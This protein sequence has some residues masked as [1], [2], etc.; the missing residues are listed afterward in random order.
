MTGYDPSWDP[1]TRARVQRAM[2]HLYASVTRI[3]Y[4]H[5][6]GANGLFGADSTSDVVGHGDITGIIAVGAKSVIE[7]IRR[8]LDR[9]SA[10]LAEVTAET[11]AYKRQIYGPGYR[12]SGR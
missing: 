3:L 2:D 4:A 7:P 12:P 6:D 11:D 9:A 10:V 1:A 8:E 5:S